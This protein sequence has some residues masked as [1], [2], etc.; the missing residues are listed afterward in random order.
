MKMRASTVEIAEP[1]TPS[2]GEPQLAV[3]QH[4]VAEPV[5][6]VGDDVGEGNDAHLAHSLQVAARAAVEQQRQRAPVEDA[7]VGAGGGGN[8]RRDAEAGEAVAG[9]PE[10]EHQWRRDDAGQID[11]LR[12]PAMALVVIVAA[13][14]LGDQRV[15]AEEQADAEERRRV[16]D[17][18]A[19]GD[20]ADGGGAQRADHDGVDDALGHP[21][22]LAQDDRN[23]E[24][25]ERAEFGC[26]VVFGLSHVSNVRDGVHRD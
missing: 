9:D 15:E 20:R 13:V 18:V 8:F 5:E 24:N 11:A 17:G 21:A 7:Q 12:Q 16:V 3:D 22:E 26:P 19:E 1:L 4:P 2:A 10:G 23:R 6:Q 14:G 25:N